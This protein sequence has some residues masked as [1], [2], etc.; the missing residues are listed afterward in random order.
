MLRN[1]VITYID[2]ADSD[3]AKSSCGFR[4]SSDVQSVKVQKVSNDYHLDLDILSQELY[5]PH[6]HQDTATIIVRDEETANNVYE[7]LYESK[8]N[9]WVVILAAPCAWAN[10][11]NGIHLH[12]CTAAII[13]SGCK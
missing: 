6:E 12:D 11:S 1:E 9:G 8:R 7:A 4:V 5:T 2:N 3:K 13:K 10:D